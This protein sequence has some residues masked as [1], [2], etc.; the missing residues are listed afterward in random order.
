MATA[1]P[2]N[3]TIDANP[4]GGTNLDQPT[5]NGATGN[6][7]LRTESTGITT[8][9]TGDVP[10]K[11]VNA[12]YGDDLDN[13]INDIIST[14]DGNYLLIGA[15]IGGDS[16]DASVRKVTPHGSVLWERA[17]GDELNQSFS[18]GIQTES[19]DYVLAGWTET[20]ES[21]TGWGVKIDKGG[22]KLWQVEQDNSEGEF[23]DVEET[24]NGQYFFVGNYNSSEADENAEVVKV[25]TN[26]AKIWD[27]IYWAKN[28]RNPQDFAAIER[29]ESDRFVLVGSEYI[30]DEQWD[31]WSLKIDSNGEFVS[32]ETYGHSVLNDFFGD[33]AITEG[34]EP[35]Y[36]GIRNGVYDDE[37]NEYNFYDAWVYYDGSSST[38]S[39]EVSVDNINRFNSISTDGNRIVAGGVSLVEEGGQR[40]GL[41]VEYGLDETR[42][43]RLTT[44]ESGDYSIDDVFVSGNDTYVAGE[45]NSS[46][47]D[48]FDG[49]LRKYTTATDSTTDSQVQLT[50]VELSQN[51]ISNNSESDRTLTFDAL[52]VS[53]DDQQDNFTVTMPQSV[54]LVAVTDVA[55][56]NGN[57]DVSYSNT[58]DAIQFHVDPDRDVASVDLA[59]EVDMTLTGRG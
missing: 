42:N 21:Y 17:Y 3:P 27:F 34:G 6:S 19:G 40:D 15:D 8:A 10:T 50:N 9:S 55:V 28:E 51:S 13:S 36:A 37:A 43:W 7:T 56:T 45:I 26:G 24:D 22:S 20:V 4:I 31:A 1:A 16:N 58:E 35:V 46:D 54:E 33:V 39:K 5:D 59:F 18:G 38:W 44:D 2:D 30:N 12:T 49:S 47:S 32:S 11:V 53:S 41:V 52:N 48:N 57:Y 29:I 23:D 25:T 14:S